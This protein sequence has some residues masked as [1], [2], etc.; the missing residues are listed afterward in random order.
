[1]GIGMPRPSPVFSNSLLTF[2]WMKYFRKS[3]ETSTFFAP[4][5]IRLQA[6]AAGL[7]TGLPSLLS[8][9]PIVTILS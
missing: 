1:M 6:L 8:A 3:L 5:G 9:R 7:G 4:F 2:G